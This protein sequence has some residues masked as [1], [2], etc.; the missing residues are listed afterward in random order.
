MN[1]AKNQEPKY[2]RRKQQS[3]IFAKNCAAMPNIQLESTAIKNVEQL[4]ILGIM[5]TKIIYGMS[6]S[7]Y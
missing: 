4:K 7:N 2:R 6:T 5:F 3:S 1:G